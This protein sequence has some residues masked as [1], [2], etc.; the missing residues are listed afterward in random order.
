M[1]AGRTLD[2]QIV[3]K[4][5]QVRQWIL[6]GKSRGF[7]YDNVQ[8]ELGRSIGKAT[9]QRYLERWGLTR[10]SL[11]AENSVRLTAMVIWLFRL[12]LTDDESTRVLLLEGFNISTRRYGKIRRK[13]GLLKRTPPNATEAIDAEI[14]EHLRKAYAEGLIEDFG[15]SNLMSYMRQKWYIPGRCVTRL[16]EGI[17]GE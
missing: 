16:V 4:E 5:E 1:P 8:L 17:V 3:A 7:I 12:Q 9:F 11:G 13:L 15:R 6:E 14:E 10:E 2:P